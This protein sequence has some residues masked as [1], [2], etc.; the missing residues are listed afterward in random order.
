[1]SVERAHGNV[2]DAYIADRT[3]FVATRQAVA[4]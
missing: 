2:G 4:R 3:L 1:M